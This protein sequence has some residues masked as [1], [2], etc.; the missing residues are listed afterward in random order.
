MKLE[1]SLKKFDALTPYELYAVLQL[2]NQVFVVEQHCV[3]QDADDKDLHCYHLMGFYQNTLMAY[4]R[5]VPPGIIYP[6]ISI[7][8]VVTSPLFR[9][10]GAGKELMQKSIDAA[11]ELFGIKVIKIGAQLYLKKFYEGFGFQ[12]TSDVYIEDG[13]SHIYMIK[14]TS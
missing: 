11:H 6:E 10:R 14:T 9:G 3:F 12:Q 4:T 5:L 8:R 7:G 2:R 1:W 13:I